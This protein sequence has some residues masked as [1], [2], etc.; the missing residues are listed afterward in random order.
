MDIDIR[1]LPNTTRSSIA[2]PI[3]RYAGAS[4]VDNNMKRNDY[5]FSRYVRRYLRR[6]LTADSRRPRSESSRQG[7]SVCHLRST[8]RPQF[9]SIQENHDA[10]ISIR[11]ST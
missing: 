11:E 2:L 10:S 7:R 4:F 3:Q 1:T 6:T 8:S 5:Y 9:Q